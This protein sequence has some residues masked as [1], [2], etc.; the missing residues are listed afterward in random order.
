MDIERDESKTT[1]RFFTLE[2]GVQVLPRM[3]TGKK[4]MRRDLSFVGNDDPLQMTAYDDHTPSGKLKILPRAKNHFTW[5][6]EIAAPF[7][8]NSLPLLT[9]YGSFSELVPSLPKMSPFH[10][11]FG[12]STLN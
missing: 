5:S 1:P 11:Q 2:V 12:L 10:I 4:L 6:F 9:P 7:L 8:Q 3:S